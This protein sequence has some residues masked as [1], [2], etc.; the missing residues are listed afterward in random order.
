MRRALAVCRSFRSSSS[1]AWRRDIG[2]V[3][4]IDRTRRLPRR[5]SV[6]QL[7]LEEA[8]RPV[9]PDIGVQKHEALGFSQGLVDV[10]PPI[11]ALSDLLREKDLVSRHYDP[12]RGGQGLGGGRMFCLVA[13]KY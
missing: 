4:A 3:Q 12:Q 5:E 10:C 1:R 13:Q 6:E 9:Q 8:P 2:R 11:V 7:H